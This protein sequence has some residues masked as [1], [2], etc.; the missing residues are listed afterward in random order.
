MTK[1]LNNLRKSILYLQKAMNEEK[2]YGYN[3]KHL[4]HALNIMLF[5]NDE[6]LNRLII[7]DKILDMEN[8]L[9][10]NINYVDNTNDFNNK[11]LDVGELYAYITK[12]MTAEEALMILLKSKTVE[13]NVLRFTKDKEIHPLMLIVMAAQ[14]LDWNIALK[15]YDDDQDEDVMGIIVGTEEYV[16]S[17]LNITDEFISKKF[18]SNNA[19]CGGNSCDGCDPNDTDAKPID[20]N[21]LR[22]A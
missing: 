3:N 19:C 13:Y 7:N 2:V 4:L 10:N 15:N 11:K 8:N 20:G 14:E 6:D 22:M 9:E 18:N 1:I 17:V 16:N 5:I 21:D 12:H